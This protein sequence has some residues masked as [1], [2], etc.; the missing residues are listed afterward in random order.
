MAPVGDA[1]VARVLAFHQELAR[2]EI[3]QIPQI[4]LFSVPVEIGEC[5]GPVE[6]CPDVDLYVSVNSGDLYEP[7]RVY[8]LPRS[9]GWSVLDGPTPFVTKG[10]NDPVSVV[11]VQTELPRANVSSA[12]REVW[13][14]I[15]YELMISPIGA[16]YTVV[17]R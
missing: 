4:V 10:Q 15:V 9:K 3:G 11:R 1:D 14:P 7:A 2:T 8:Q 12:D 6:S 17:P 5:G 13:L 16:K